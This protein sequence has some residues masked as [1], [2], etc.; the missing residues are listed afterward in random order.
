MA[1]TI[2]DVAEK[3]D[4]SISTVS[5][6][7]NQSGRISEGTREKVLAVARDLNYSPR[8]YTKKRQGKNIGIL[9]NQFS[10]PIL[11]NPFY[12]LILKG[13]EKELNKREFHLVFKTLV[14]KKD[15]DEQTV[16]SVLNDKQFKG[17]IVAGY[18]IDISLIKHI[19]D[20]PLP[21]VLVDND[22]WDE[23]ID[24][25][26]ND[27]ISGAR[28]IVKGLVERGHERIAFIGGP[29]SHVSF[30]KRYMGYKMALKENNIEKDNQ[31][32]LFGDSSF[33]VE[34]GYK[35]TKKLLR[36]LDEKPT[37]LFAVNDITAI[38]AM[39]A[40][41]EYGY[42]IP[43]DIAVAGF[44]DINMGR[45]VSPALTTV[46]V[47][48]E[49]MGVQAAKRLLELNKNISKQPIKIVLSVKPVFR[50]STGD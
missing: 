39:K 4:V 45:H 25:V 48:K 40:I 38:G 7:F 37:A 11:N 49:N 14:G 12:S 28:K 18:G 29:F 43:E 6:V 5:R 33:Q 31:L 36:R 22:H 2:E 50:G 26:L 8:K 1:V 3:A 16:K 19:K 13:I 30:E 9:I 24:C 20:S 34:D 27:N 46:R 47:F 17:L 44:D 41:K 35:S 15:S 21:V 23:D 42:S 32:I 10:L